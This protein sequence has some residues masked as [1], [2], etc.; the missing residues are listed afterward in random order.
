MLI[1]RRVCDCE[2]SY[3][4]EVMRIYLISLVAVLLCVHR[5]AMNEVI[6][7]EKSP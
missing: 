7:P 6:V 4:R 1:K 2:Y 5:P 3:S